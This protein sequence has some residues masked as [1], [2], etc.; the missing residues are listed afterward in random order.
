MVKMSYTIIKQS[1][2]VRYINGKY[3]KSPVAISVWH[4]VKQ[5][6]LYG[7]HQAFRVSGAFLFSHF[8][9]P[10][11]ATAAGCGYSYNIFNPRRR[12]QLLY[13]CLFFVLSAGVWHVVVDLIH[14]E[15]L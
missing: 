15:I 5:L 12:A 11:T 9:A 6:R 13:N 7:K 8:I 10:L 1:L 2:P 14:C 4:A 3:G